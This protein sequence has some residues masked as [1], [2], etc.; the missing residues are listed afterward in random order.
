MTLSK[1]KIYNL[2][3]IILFSLFIAI[4]FSAPASAQLRGSEILKDSIAA[5]NQ[6]EQSMDDMWDAL[7]GANA[8]LYTQLNQTA[9]YIKIIGFPFVIMAFG[10]AMKEHNNAKVG[11]IVAWVIIIVAF[12]ANDGA[13]LKDCTVGMRNIVNQEA[14]ALLQV[15]ITNLTIQDAMQ[16]II[17]TQ[18]MRD[19]VRDAYTECESKEGI[20]QLECLKEAGDYAEII[21]KQYEDAGFFTPGIRRFAGNFR[22]IQARTISRLNTVI[23]NPNSAPPQLDTLSEVMETSSDEEVGLIFQ[24]LTGAGNQVL[25]KSFQNW[26]TYGFEFA[27]M[28]TGMLGPLAMA[29][30]MIP[31]NPRA[32]FTWGIGFLSIGVLKLSYNLVVGFAALYA[33][34]TGAGDASSAGFLTMVS[35][36]AP[37]ISVAVA[38]GGGA[39]IFFALGKTTAAMATVVTVGAQAATSAMPQKSR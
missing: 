22:R 30:S 38:G 36:G 7:F 24:S 5:A 21:V 6:S 20:A 10:N 23:N 28:L 25:L 18:Q 35:F 14:E 39:A 29:A 26:F 13:M 32:I 33:S 12:L 19:R 37:L 17:L 11:E 1:D 2:L 16:D 4:L 8:A 3:L 34:M 31:K 27:M 9:I 15:Q